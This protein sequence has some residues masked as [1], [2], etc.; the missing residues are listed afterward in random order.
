[1]RIDKALIDITGE[2]S[3]GAQQQVAG[4]RYI[5][6][7]QSCQRNTCQYRLQ[8]YDNLRQRQCSL[9]IR[10]HSL[11][12]KTKEGS[13]NAYRQHQNAAPDEALLS[14]CSVLSAQRNL[15]NTLQRKI[16]GNKCY[17]P[18]GDGYRANTV[19]KAEPWHISRQSSSQMIHAANFFEL[20]NR[21]RQDTYVNQNNIQYIR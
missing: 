18:A 11:G 15:Q 17:N 1:M 13:Q 14:S 4:G 7:P 20:D 5:R 2:Q 16:Y 19:N 3:S 6:S 12:N 8:A 21:C 10:I 9:R